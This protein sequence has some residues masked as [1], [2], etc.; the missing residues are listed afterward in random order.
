MTF[1][2]MRINHYFV[3][4]TIL[5]TCLT[6]RGFSA[7]SHAVRSTN[8]NGTE[9]AQGFCNSPT[10]PE[11]LD[12]CANKTTTDAVAKETTGLPAFPGAEGHG[13]YT[14]GGRGG[15]VYFVT[16]L[17]DNNLPGSLRYA[18]EQVGSRI[19]I[20]SVSGTIQLTSELKI[21]NP[22]MTI[23]GQTAPGDGITLRNY[24]VSVNAD[25]VII[26]F[27][28]FRMGDETKTE[29]DAI[30]GRYHKN[31]IIDH[32]SMSW[33]T[34]E[35][36]SFY[37]NEDFTLQ[38]CI[39]SESLRYSVHD[40]GAH[41]YGGIWGGKRASFHHNLL[42]HHDSRNP[43]L[44]EA[45]GDAYAL[46]DN[47][48]MR[49]NVVYNWQGNSCYGAEAMNVNI[50]NCYYKPGPATSKPERIIAIDKNLTEGTAVYNTWG[51]FYIDGN[52]LSASERATTDN[53]TYGVYNQY[54]SKY[55]TVSDEDKTAMR[56]SEPHPFGEVTTQSAEVAYNKVIQFGGAS[57]IRDAVD[58][59]IILDVKTGTATYMTGGNGS[60]NGII[61]TQTA[62]GGWPVLTTLTTPA[63]TD[64]DGMPDNWETAKSLDPNNPNDAQLKTVDGL[65]PNIEVYI[66]SLVA[67]IIA[68]QNNNDISTG[69][70]EIETD[71]PHFKAYYNRGQNQLV[72]AH[73][74]AINEIRLFDMSGR[75]CLLNLTNEQ[76]PQLSLPKLNQGIYIVRIRDDKLN[77]LAEKVW[78]S[79][80]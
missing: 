77:W 37:I 52:I 62:V 48:D 15:K 47:V 25:N 70:S 72:I 20:F 33:S 51:K 18:I 31:I 21:E 41:G 71:K 46:T 74:S 8:L 53:W 29:A 61:D 56:L 17:V 67:D 11:L 26:R 59:R 2:L 69:L 4:M 36:V 39:I 45:A 19:I 3:Y 35:C 1:R 23:A 32:C 42:A 14:T 6:V 38:W 50:V 75:L 13:K 78:I 57:L 64:Q 63:D 65:Y 76:K 79:N 40:K 43:R 66:N 30:G 55:G 16:T 5:L 27:M 22:N 49:N 7:S 9:L 28:R 12:G 24:P 68:D 44:G 54:H 10:N 60:V 34:D 58:L 80:E 73:E